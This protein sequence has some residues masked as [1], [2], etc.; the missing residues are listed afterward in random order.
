MISENYSICIHNDNRTFLTPCS[1]GGLPLCC[2]FAISFTVKL[3]MT[4]HADSPNTADTARTEGSTLST[5]ML[6]NSVS[7]L[8]LTLGGVCCKSFDNI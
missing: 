2:A 8:K 3:W 7:L 5:C 4:I 6:L 1:T